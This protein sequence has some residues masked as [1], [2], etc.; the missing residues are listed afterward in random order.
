[1]GSHA[2]PSRQVTE[3]DSEDTAAN[4]LLLGSDDGEIIIGHIGAHLL[5]DTG[6][7]TKFC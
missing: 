3:K 7:N 5:N 1:M 4:L 2:A 6:L